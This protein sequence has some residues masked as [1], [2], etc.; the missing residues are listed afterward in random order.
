MPRILFVCIATFVCSFAFVSH[1]TLS[2]SQRQLA[3]RIIS[4]GFGRNIVA[5]AVQKFDTNEKQVKQPLLITSFFLSLAH[6]MKS[7]NIGSL[8]ILTMSLGKEC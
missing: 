2:P 6:V 5:R 7:L 1:S 4:M 8:A 3:N